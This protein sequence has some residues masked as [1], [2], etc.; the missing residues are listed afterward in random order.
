MAAEREEVVVAPDP[1]G[2][3]EPEHLAPE[4]GHRL[5]GRGLRRRSGAR[6]R[7][8]RRGQGRAVDFAVRIE[9]QRVEQ[10]EH[11]GD[12]VVG[13]LGAQE[14]PQRRDRIIQVTRITRAAGRAEDGVGCELRA[15]GPGVDGGDR[16]GHVRVAQ[17]RGLHLPQLD[18]EAA[19]LDLLVGA[20]SP[21]GCR[22]QRRPSRVSNFS[23]VSSSR[24]Q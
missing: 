5:F 23:A 21:A 11:R 2:L 10:H 17:Q 15:G 20:T 12:H 7:H 14:P 22:N 16:R 24:R 4:R 3:V 6:A 18:A 19:H 1:G 13:Q 9:R 8:R